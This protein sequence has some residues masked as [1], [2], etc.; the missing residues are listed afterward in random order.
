MITKNENFVWCTY[1]N[2]S[3]EILDALIDLNTSKCVSILTT[4][5]CV[6]DFS[7]FENRISQI[8]KSKYSVAINSCTSSLF[9]SLKVL[10]IKN[11][12]VNFYFMKFMNKSKTRSIFVSYFL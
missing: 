2:W 1:R 9:L 10:D 12:S 6:Y 4:K 8:T 7:K 3:F 5:T 11:E